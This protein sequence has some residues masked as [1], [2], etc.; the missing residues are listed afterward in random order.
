MKILTNR[1]CFPSGKLLRNALINNKPDIGTILV[2]QFANKID[3]YPFIRYGNSDPILISINKTKYNSP[4][5]IRMASYKKAFSILMNENNIYSPVYR[6]GDLSEDCVFPILIRTQLS[7]SGGK[8]IYLI[9]NVDKFN[10]I[11]KSEYWWTPFIKT[12][13]ELRVHILG[14]NIVRIFKKIPNNDVESQQYPIRNNSCCHFSLR[15]IN[16]Y[17]KLDKLV[18]KLNEILDGKFYSLDVGWDSKKGEY[19]LYEIN[20]ASGLNE[21]TADIYAKYLIKEMGL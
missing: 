6:K 17:P 20:S 14:D 15:N 19:F 2:T 1:G 8:G 5:F 9:E 18:E 21:N 7:L 13:F 16:N 4:N 10:E 12:S 11:W 3:S